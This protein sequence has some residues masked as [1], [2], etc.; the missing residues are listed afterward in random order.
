[1]SAPERAGRSRAPARRREAA[2]HP[3]PPVDA[4]H[5]QVDVQ[6]GKRVT[7]GD[8][9]L[10]HAVD[11]RAIKIE[12]K[13]GRGR[14]AVVGQTGHGTTLGQQADRALRTAATWPD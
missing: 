3:H 6:C 7:P 12:E 14:L 13:G 10:V 4:P 9:V 11:E 8:H 1:M 5:R 2:A